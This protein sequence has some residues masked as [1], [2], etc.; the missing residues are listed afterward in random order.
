MRYGQNVVRIGEPGSGKTEATVTSIAQSNG[1]EV[2]LDPHEDS[3]ARKALIH[4]EGNVLFARLSDV[5]HA[6]GFELLKQSND[7]LEN[8]LRAE[9]FVDILVRRRNAD[10]LA[11]TPLL[12][13]WVMAALMLVLF[14]RRPKPIRWLPSAFTPGTKR[15]AALLR[16]CQLADVRRKFRFL[17]TLSPRALR[18]EV[19]SASRLITSVFRSP[20]FIAWSQ[21]GFDLGGFLEQK[22]RLIVE[23]GKEIGHDTMRTI[24]AAIILLTITYAEQ[25]KFALPTIRVRIDEATNAGLL[26]NTE[27]KAAAEHNKRGLYFEFNLQRLDVPCD[28][29]DLLQLCHRHEWYRCSNYEL[30]RKAATDIV[31]GLPGSDQPR[32]QRVAAIA[33]EI[34]NFS[35]GWRF[36]RDRSGS[37]KEYVPM[38]QNPWPDWP[39]LREAKLQEKLQLIYNRTEYRKPD[40]PT[41]TTTSRCATRPS[42]RLPEP[43]SPALRL[44]QRGKR[45]TDGSA[46]N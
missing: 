17:S 4:T 2:N 18:A 14:Q 36:V 7:P 35:L 8:H 23:R 12:E 19:G 13:E 40:E 22:G 33:D 5:R 37:R 31:A 41:S 11:A 3:L 45:P 42:N 29:N 26:T 43:D 39:G 30:A 25:R 34:M 9:A 21:G 16:G 10:G 6:I 24:M 15:F 20:A 1:A 32:A 28:P 46:R 44:K 27:L 38:L